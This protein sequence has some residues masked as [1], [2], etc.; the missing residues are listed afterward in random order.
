[1]TRPRRTWLSSRATVCAIRERRP[2]SLGKKGLAEL[3]EFATYGNSK[4]YARVDARAANPK[5]IQYIIYL[6]INI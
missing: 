6:P 5:K 4:G 2:V 3:H 1:M